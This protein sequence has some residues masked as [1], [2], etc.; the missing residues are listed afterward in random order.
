MIC[1]IYVNKKSNL[2]PLLYIFNK[3]QNIANKIGFNYRIISDFH[4][5]RNQKNDLIYKKT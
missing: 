5:L 2:K 4:H 3:I 1:K